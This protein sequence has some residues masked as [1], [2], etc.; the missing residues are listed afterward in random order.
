[1]DGHTGHSGGLS[2]E[3]WLDSHPED[4]SDY[5]LRKADVNLVNRWLSAHGFTTLPEFPGARR[6]T[7]LS[8]LSN[9][10]SNPSSP[11]ETRCNDSG[12][13]DSARHQRS[14]SKKHLRHDYARSKK[15]NLFRTY[16]SS[17]GGESTLESRRN[18]LK[19]MRQ[20]RSLPPTSVNLLSMLIQSKVR[21]PRYPSKDIDHKR[22]LKDTN[23][24]EFFLEIVKDISNE[25]DLKN[26]TA[27]I[28]GNVSCMLDADKVSIFL[29]EGKA[30]S[31]PSLVSKLF[32]LHAGT[33]IFPSCTGDIRVPWGQGVIGHV[34]ATGETVNLQEA[35]KDARY[36]DELSRITGYHVETLL[37]MPIKNGDNEIVGVAQAL[38]KNG[39]E[40][41]VFTSDDEKILST[42]RP[43]DLKHFNPGMHACRPG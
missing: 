26:L 9:E 38:N 28:V 12:F 34:A 39:E 43:A 14:N 30:T 17:S 40:E 11:V 1:M 33:N 42:T 15:R 5:F 24:R 25:L 32:D 37:C 21:L 2:V 6:N 13:F 7:S 29:V 4:M 10:S 36:N 31:K 27:K 19:E 18:S 8:T 20:F 35:M 3:E 22:D 16:E 23:E 41:N